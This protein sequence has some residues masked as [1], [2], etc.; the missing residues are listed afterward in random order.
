MEGDS[1]A[2]AVAQADE[3]EEAA[4][5]SDSE[6]GGLPV[7]TG[8]TLTEEVKLEHGEADNHRGALPLELGGPDARALNDSEADAVVACDGV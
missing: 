3:E 6:A 2:V 1:D 4:A 8:D 5:V 7:V